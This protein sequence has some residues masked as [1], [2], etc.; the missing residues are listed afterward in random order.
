MK[1]V[2]PEYA[3]DYIWMHKNRP[4]KQRRVSAIMTV[5]MWPHGI[6]LTAWYMQ[7]NCIVVNQHDK[8]KSP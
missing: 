6:G 5:R 7:H 8:G 3:S 1:Q 4:Y 2:S